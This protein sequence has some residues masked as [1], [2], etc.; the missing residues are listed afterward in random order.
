MKPNLFPCPSSPP[1]PEG[2]PSIGVP[3]FATMT[4]DEQIAYAM[5]MSMQPGEEDEDMEA[6]GESAAAAAAA[7][8]DEDYS[9]VMTDPDF[10]H[11]VLTS[12]PGENEFLGKWHGPQRPLREQIYRYARPHVIQREDH[13]NG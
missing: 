2:F 5:R 3:D 7:V 4:E 13:E 10:L 12:L 6:D 11:D 9:D 1:R 8:K